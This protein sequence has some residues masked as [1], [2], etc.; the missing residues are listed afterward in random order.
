MLLGVSFFSVCV[1]N[2]N[3]EQHFHRLFATLHIGGRHCI[4]GF[5]WM[6]CWC[7]LGTPNA[8]RSCWQDHYL[9][10]RSSITKNWLMLISS[11]I[12]TYGLYIF[13]NLVDLHRV[14][15][16]MQMVQKCSFETALWLSL[17]VHNADIKPGLIDEGA[18]STGIFSLLHASLVWVLCPFFCLFTPMY[19]WE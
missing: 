19:P 6:A 12:F 2:W 13:K 15:N 11:E 16:D 18:D 4:V 5:E 9:F 10:S 7:V 3:A 8:A 1:H 14:P 17:W